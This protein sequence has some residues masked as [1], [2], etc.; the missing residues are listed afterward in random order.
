MIVRCKNGHYYDDRRYKTCPHCGID[1]NA[2]AAKM[3]GSAPDNDK[4]LAFEAPDDSKT[5]SYPEED[6][7]VTVSYYSA[8]M[9]AEPVVGWLVCISGEDKGRDF[10][11]KAGRNSIGRANTNDIVLRSDATVSREGHAEIVYDHRSNRTFIVSG[12]S[13]EVMV[14][15]VIVTAPKE[16]F[17]R[18]R[19]RIGQTDFV[20]AP[21]CFGDLNWDVLD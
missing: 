2:Y 12:N 15:G 11:I 5:V 20:F 13:T 6:D 3:Q 18:D 1:F 19:I 8:K 16:L 10:R 17:G 14:G 4:T 7:A 21:F 9:S